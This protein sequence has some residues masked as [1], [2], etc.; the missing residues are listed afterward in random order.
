VVSPVTSN[1][2]YV[3]DVLNDP[4]IDAHKYP[5]PADARATRWPH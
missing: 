4:H 1:P 3:N 2:G 5:V